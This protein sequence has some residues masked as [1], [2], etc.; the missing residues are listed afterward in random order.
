[1]ETL[2]TPELKLVVYRILQE[3]LNNAIRHSKATNVLIRI[4]KK[5]NNIELTVQDD[6]IGF[7]I[8][9]IKK[10][11][12]LKNIENRVYLINGKL[13]VNTA[14]GSGCTLMVHFPFKKIKTNPQ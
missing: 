11:I 12:G 14:P 10:G 8:A 2:L 6:G 5:E 13:Q 7:N 4:K 3:A 9:A 1:M